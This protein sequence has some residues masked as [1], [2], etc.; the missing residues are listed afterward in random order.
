M[1]SLEYRRLRGDTITFL[2]HIEIAAKW[3]GQAVP[4][5]QEL[6]DLNC[7]K[8][9]LSYVTLKH[10]GQ[11][12]WGDCRASIIFQENSLGCCLSLPE[13]RLAQSVPPWDQRRGHTM[14]R[15][16]LEQQPGKGFRQLIRAVV[17][18]SHHC[19][20]FTC[21]LPFCLLLQSLTNPKEWFFICLSLGNE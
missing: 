21:H 6:M 18:N 7:R 14:S 1:H 15:S 11:I 4:Q 13:D 10:G 9:A 12:A 20:A 16:P 8:G 19:G 3:K 5:L 2:K 17:V